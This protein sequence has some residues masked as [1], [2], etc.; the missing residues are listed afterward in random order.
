MKKPDSLST[1]NFIIRELASELVISKDIVEAIVSHQLE[2]M[3]KATTC[4]KTVEF[5]GF[6]KF[7]L[8]ERHVYKT[9]EGFT[10]TKLKLEGMLDDPLTERKLQTV[11][12]KLL[13][14]EKMMAQIK[15]YEI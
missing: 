12:K 3:I 15:K 6:G 4:H 7:I 9:V 1:K 14:I 10:R 2:G 5:S 11:R 13:S 8:N